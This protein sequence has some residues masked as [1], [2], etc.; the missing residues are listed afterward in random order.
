MAHHIGWAV[1]MVPVA[2]SCTLP[3]AGSDAG[4]GDAGSQTLGDQCSVI[5]A[6]FCAH[7]INDC[8]VADSLSDCIANETPTCCVGSACAAT[9]RST[10]SAVAS[11]ASAIASEDCNSVVTAGPA[12]LGVCQGVP[13]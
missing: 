9:A 3:N 6:A 12:A 2:I 10:R 1:A 8:G 7:A 4:E 13:Q 11:C 5:V